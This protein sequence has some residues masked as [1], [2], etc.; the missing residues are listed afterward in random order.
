MKNLCTEIVYCNVE[1]S[2][3][4]ILFRMMSGEV[5]WVEGG[6]GAEVAEPVP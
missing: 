4:Y 3:K 1:L 2:S 6:A 5:A